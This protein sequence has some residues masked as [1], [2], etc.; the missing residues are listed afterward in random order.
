MNNIK[1][2][3]QITETMQILGNTIAQQMGVIFN[4]L[5][6]N[7]MMCFTCPETHGTFCAIDR[8]EAI[9]KYVRVLVDFKF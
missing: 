2:T 6:D 8:K 7:N 3:T 1:N 9:L 5:W 4:G